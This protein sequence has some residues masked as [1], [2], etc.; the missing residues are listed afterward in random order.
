MKTIIQKTIARAAS[1]LL[2]VMATA[3]VSAETATYIDADGNEQTVESVAVTSSTTTFTDGGWYV[4]NG[5]V[6][7]KTITVNGTA[8]LILADGATLTSTGTPTTDKY[9]PGIQVT[10]GNTLIIYGQRAGTGELVA[11]GTDSKAAGIGGGSSSDGKTGV[12]CGT[13]KIYG[14]IITATGMKGAAGIGGGAGSSSSNTG[15]A[16]GT[17][18]IYGGTVT[19]TGGSEANGTN[20]YGPGIGGGT[21]NGLRASNGTLTVAKGM[22]VVAGTDAGSATARTPDAETGAVTI[23]T[24]GTAD[25][26][27]SITA[28]TA[29]TQTESDLGEVEQGAEKSWNLAETLE[30]NVTPYVF[31]GDVPA[32]FTFSDGVLTLGDAAGGIYNITLTAAGSAAPRLS[33]P[34]EFTWTV[35]VLSAPKAI[36]YMD[37]ENVLD[38][39]P[40]SYRPGIGA[41]LPTPEKTGYDFGGWYTNAVFEGE[42]ATEVATTETEDLTFY[43][44]WTVTNYSIVYMDGEETLNLAPASYT[45]LAG[46]TLPTDV[47]KTGYTFGGWYAAS[48]FTGDAVTEIALGTTGN[49]TFYSKW[50]AISYNIVY[51]GVEE[52]LNPATYTIEDEVT[53][54]TPEKTGYDFGGWYTNSVFEGEAVSEI[55]LGSTEDRTFYAKWTATVYTITYMDGSTPLD[56]APA[57]YTIEAAE[58]LPAATKEGKDFIGWYDNAGFTGDAVTEIAL[59]STGAKTFYAKFVPSRAPATYIDADGVEQT[60]PLCITIDDADPETYA[61]EDGGWYVVKS[62]A[63]FT[64]TLSIP[65]GASINLILADGASLTVTATGTSG[66]SR[67]YPGIAV[68]EN[69]SL[70]I[71]AQGEGTGTLSATGA[72]RGAGIGGSGNGGNCGAVTINGGNITATGKQYAA[73]IGGAGNSGGTGGAGGVVTVNGGTVTATGGT[74]AIGGGRNNND[75]GTLTVAPGMRDTGAGTT[76]T[77]SEPAPLA[78]SVSELQNGVEGEGT[79]WDLAE[80]VTGGVV[81]YVFSGTA[82]EGFSFTE[83]GVLT[84]GDAKGGDYSITLT[85][86]DSGSKRFV[87]SKEFTWTVTIL[88]APKTITYMDGEET[89]NLAPAQYNPGVAVALPVP[90]K[91]GYDFGGWYTNSVFEGEVVTEVATTETEDL[92]FFSKWTATVYN[93]TYMDGNTAIEGLEPTTY[94]VEA[95][96][97]LPETAEKSGY[98]FYGW[99][100]NSATTGDE[101]TEIA[102]G[103]TGDKV[104]YAKW[105]LPWTRADYIDAAGAPA[106]ERCV[107]VTSSTRTLEGGNWYAVTE[108]TTVS[109]PITVSGSVNL[110]L[111]DGAT[112][113]VSGGSTQYNAGIAVPT[114]SS[115][116]IYAQSAGTGAIAATGASRGAGIGGSGSAGASCGTV[117]IYGGRIT[118]TGG[119]RGAGIGGAGAGTNGTGGAGGT[120]A[121][122]GGSV[123]ANGGQNAAGIGGGVGSAGAT[124]GQGTLTVATGMIVKVG[125]GANPTASPTINANGEVTLSGSN[126]RYFTITEPGA[127]V[128][129]ESALENGVESIPAEWNLAATISGGV[130]GYSFAGE[131]PEGF[132]LTAAGVLSTLATAKAG[133]YNITVT[134]T[135]SGTGRIKKSVPFTWTVT[136]LNAPKAITYMDGAETLTGLEPTQY[137][138]GVAATLPTPE[139]TGYTFGG[140][141]TNSV[142]EG[143][144]VTEVATTETEDLT[145]YS[146]WTATVYSIV[147]MDGDTAIEG[148]EPTT[149]TIEEAVKLPTTEKT[150]Y[151]FDG[152]Y[153]NADFE[154]DAVTEIAL[155][156]T[157]A[158]TFYAKWTAISYNIVYMD[159]ETT[160]DLTPAT[161]TIED[162]VTLPTPVKTGYDFGGWYTNSVFEGDVV[163]EIALGSTEDRTFYAKW[164]ATVYTITYMDGSTTIEGL[165]PTNYTIEAAETLPTATK[166]GKDF[167][168]WYDNAGFAGDAVT[169]IDLGSTG[170]KMF[171]AKFVP[172]RAPAT[173]IDADG[174]EQT[175]PLCITID[176]TDPDTYAFEDGGW[177]VVKSDA[178]FAS[179]LSIPAGAS[180]NLILADGAT[181]RA[182][183]ASSGTTSYNPGIAVPATSTLSIYAQGEGS[184]AIVAT[185]TSRGAGIGGS[186]NGG[187][188]G[189][190]NIYGGNITATGT[191]YGAGIGGAGT[192]SSGTGGAGGTV[193]IYGG[194][195][196]ATGGANSA[197]IGGGRNASSQGTLT[198]APGMVDTT[199]GYTRT[200]TEPAPLAQ[201]ASTLDNGVEGEGTSW[202][203]AETVTGGVT[204]YLFSGEAP[205]GFSFTEAGVLTLGDAKGGDYSITLTVTDSGSKRYVQ[206]TNFTWTVTI[207]NA[208]KTITY[209]D[210]EETLNLAPAQYNPGVGVEL[211]ASAEKTGYEFVGWFDNAELTGDAVT[212]VATTETEDLTFYAKW[213]AVVYTIT[214]MDGSSKIE[215]LVPTNY[216][217]EAAA[218][219][220]ETAEKSGYGFYGWY[221][222]SATTGDEVTEIAKGTT[223]DKV[224]YAKWGT[225]WVAATYIGADG[226]EATARSIVMTSSTTTFEDGGWYVV[227]SDLTMGTIT[228]SGSANLILADGATLTVAGSNKYDPGVHVSVGNTLSIYAQSA[229]TGA[230]VASGNESKAAGIGGGT[231]S[232]GKTGESCGAVRIY[233]GN[234]TATGAKGAAG[235]GGGAGSGSDNTKKGGDG[236]TVEVY[237]GI[238][239]ATGGADNGTGRVGGAG[240]GSGDAAGGV[241]SGGTFVNYGGTVIA[242]G[243]DEAADIGAADGGASATFTIVGGSTYLANGTKTGDATDGN[244]NAVYCVTVPDLEANT[245]YVFKN[246]GNYGQA[247]IVSDDGGNVYLW[248]ADGGHSFTA[249]G[250]EWTATVDG[251]NTTAV[252]DTAAVE[253][254]KVVETA[255]VSV[256]EVCTVATLV[257][258]EGERRDVGDKIVA[259]NTK[260]GK[261]DTW[262]LALVGEDLVWEPV[263]RMSTGSDVVEYPAAAA[264][265]A[266]QSGQ[267]VWVQ[268]VNENKPIILN[269]KY[270]VSRDQTVTVTSGWTLLAPIPKVGETGYD[271]NDLTVEGGEFSD[272]DK[273]VISGNESPVNCF[274]KDGKWKVYTG[275]VEADGEWGAIFTGGEWVPA[276]KIVE[277]EGFFF[278]TEDGKTLRF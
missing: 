35:T 73:G 268:R 258:T 34:V 57:S 213:T 7:T 46:V 264:E 52:T 189:T 204:N 218:T 236:G 89:L 166:D 135:D 260:T 248:L 58:T 224:F 49:K 127:L 99:F 252:R 161:Y 238:V 121:V 221:D 183:A 91:T 12:A 1:L 20:M 85:V 37:G 250:Y 159:G 63:T 278:V 194:S 186:G 244:G 206:T 53:L 29:L 68:P 67:F 59:G 48:D 97:T 232:D 79:S 256:P 61:F 9:K 152:W 269:S 123:T 144:A 211:P 171:Y 270:S 197:A 96:A 167:I 158:K 83:A 119:Q 71:Y 157:G 122:Y 196:T 102:L 230:L 66:D 26:Y 80:T 103:S 39:A 198:I 243:I 208:P 110:I 234:I 139:K 65:A 74:S 41:T 170:N 146:K 155:G 120:V 69:S 226:N 239:K 88:N 145:F 70:T 51:E 255:L 160:L 112:L 149:Y 205:A 98:G 32:G 40:A 199:S 214:Y 257:N 107:V 163:T 131:L 38:L 95:A 212:E 105:G 18:E 90:E 200:I 263:A 87:Q 180:V 78:Q 81:D 192:G 10:T 169:G 72:D 132:E 4:V 8:N 251:A 11:T 225:P 24:S 62:D 64:S 262:Q 60:A 201:S 114:S 164:T 16:G 84:L 33:K 117:T 28:P 261:Y 276:P 273:I 185:G 219:L 104:F 272:S 82:T 30:G 6:S 202:N 101:V 253:V 188:C 143:D 231:S 43:S 203:L 210:G 94:T 31:S 168:G 13:V 179:T 241:T 156:T 247:N 111:A 118:A 15:G 162:A 187:S 93:I 223:G 191:Q 275:T 220:P 229:G 193:T 22:T 109:G 137:N 207:L 148:L 113:T 36:V 172:S 5:T 195:V 56:L 92:T 222:N 150:G 124:A 106:S 19:A 209:K 254:E 177:Y 136:I 165:V 14:G 3:S 17:V 217:V 42:V 175:A 108:D 174:V 142:F 140:W 233:G 182:T 125:A 75:Q 27:F 266:L 235:I 116:T 54:P 153:D 134:V 86:T 21:A 277:G 147:Y 267:A 245:K 141:Y 129:S 133:D 240:I 45:I 130:P 77:I 47:T 100:D 173:Y 190:I 237:G 50:T 249:L 176:D 216:T 23:S 76:R 178:T 246:L 151:T 44:K 128:Q 126:S 215:G 55:A 25:R 227:N 2:G 115:L 274:R 228:V 184:G 259:F 154:G 271:L 138:P 181:L 242:T 265:Y